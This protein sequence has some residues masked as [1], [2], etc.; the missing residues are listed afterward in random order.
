MTDLSAAPGF[1]APPRQSILTASAQMKRRNAAETRFRAYGIIAITL[2]LVTLAIM[3][4]T[5]LRDGASAFHQAQLSFPMELSAEVLDPKGNR[6]RDEMAKVTT[7]GYQK[8]LAKAFAAELDRR[9]ISQDGLSAKDIG[10]IISKDAAGVLRA[11]VLADPAL[12]GTT[13]DAQVLAA[14]RID[15]FLKGRVTLETAKRDS[16]IK[17][18]QLLLAERLREAGMLSS[19]WNWGFFTNA[20]ASDQRP[21]AAGLGV[22]L[23]G[24][25]VTGAGLRRGRSRRAAERADDGF[26]DRIARTLHRGGR[27]LRSTLGAMVLTNLRDSARAATKTNGVPPAT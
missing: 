10:E 5:I 4:F 22:A 2:S 8:V 24:G 17:P 15:G 18:E 12:V 21:E 13:I 23:L 14:G 26:F 1:A 7:V 25:I 19:A 20:D 3:L 6:A 16:T 11:E 27:I 9:G